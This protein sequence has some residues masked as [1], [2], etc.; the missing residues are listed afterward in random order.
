[1]SP[2]ALPAAP[3]LVTM[4]EPAG[5]GGELTLMAW[6]AAQ[7]RG[8]PV[9]AAI[10]DARRLHDL[11]RKIGLDVPV[12]V[13]GAPGEAA[14]VFARALPVLDQPLTA[15]VVPG[16]PDAQNAPHVV[17]AIERA[18]AAALTGEAAGLVT[19]PVHK[20]SLYAAGFTAPGHTEFLAHAIAALSRRPARQ[21][22]MMLTARDL[23]VVP[24]TIHQPLKDA[25]AALSTP[26]I[27]AAAMITDAALRQDFALAAPRL[28]VAGLNPHAGEGGTLGRE[29]IDIIAPAIADLRQ[30]GLRIDGPL[31]ADTLFHEDAR[32]AYDAVLCMY[33]DQALIPLKTID[34]WGGVNVTLGLDVVRTSP[35][36]GTAFALAGTGR[37]NPESFF[38]ALKLAATIADNRARHG[39]G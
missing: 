6:R 23:K 31:P 27:A 28:A 5:I 8:L 26:M 30:R 1:M 9:F 32:T 35:D 37:A 19:N 29:E 3:F 33:H 7:T 25:I 16:T 11:A 38:A 22:V 20:E 39:R 10:D 24:I 21:P 13:I 12:A 36:H 34:F 2:A 14:G 18:V 4:G 17:H 15:P